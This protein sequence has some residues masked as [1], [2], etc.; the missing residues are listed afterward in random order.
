MHPDATAT[1]EARGIT[2]ATGD[3]RAFGPSRMNGRFAM[4]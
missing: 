2:A 1:S 3:A 4:E